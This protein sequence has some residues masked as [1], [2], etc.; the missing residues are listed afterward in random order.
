MSTY[1]TIKL[2]SGEKDEIHIYRDCLDDEYYFE[3]TN[4]G[5]PECKI[6]IKVKISEN[7]IEDIIKGG[8]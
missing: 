2:Y 3:F 4:W 7:L 1:S 8:I 5:N 6:E